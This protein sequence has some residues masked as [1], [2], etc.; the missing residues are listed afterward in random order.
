M[1]TVSKILAAK[2][3][4][5]WSVTPTTRLYE[6]LKLMA[7]KDIGA[8]LVL[9]EGEI[10]GII[11]ERDYARKVILEG[12]NSM[13]V[14]IGEIMT[15]DVLTITPSYTVEECMALMTNKH[16]RHLP[17]LDDDDQLS[18]LISIGDVVKEMISEQQFVIGQL[19]NYI[20]GY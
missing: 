2:G 3:S 12:K 13:I 16:V 7:E 15:K 19:E 5:V 10:V 1:T 6:A 9:E 11:S 18:G 4:Q 20:R 14:P 8:L 17:V